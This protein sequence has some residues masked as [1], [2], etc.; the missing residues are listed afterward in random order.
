MK[1]KKN[2]KAETLYA[3]FPSDRIW[4]AISHY[5]QGIQL[6]KGK[7]EKFYETY[8]VF[9]LVGQAAEIKTLTIASEAYLRS[10]WK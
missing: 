3:E 5:G 6:I 4:L 1:C 10:P 7:N 9:Q 2:S 8:L